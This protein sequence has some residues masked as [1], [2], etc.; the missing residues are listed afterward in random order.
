MGFHPSSPVSQNMGEYLAASVLCS[1]LFLQSSRL[2]RNC[3]TLLG[4]LW[5]LDPQG[6]TLSKRERH[7]RAGPA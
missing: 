5:T 4:P 6:T 7:P 2:T 1:E 3:R